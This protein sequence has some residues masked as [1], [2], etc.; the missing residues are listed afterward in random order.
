ML[1][2]QSKEDGQHFSATF[3]NLMILYFI[4]NQKD[5]IYYAPALDL[6]G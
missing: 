6:S 1:Q 4:E 2:F 3:S 5:H